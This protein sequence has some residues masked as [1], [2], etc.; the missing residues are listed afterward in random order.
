MRQMDVVVMALLSVAIGC[1][2]DSPEVQVGLVGG[3]ASEPLRVAAGT[4]VELQL[5]ADDSDDDSWQCIYGIEFAIRLESIS[6]RSRPALAAE[7][8]EATG[9]ELFDRVALQGLEPGLADLS[10]QATGERIGAVVRTIPIEV[11]RAEDVLFDYRLRRSVDQGF[12]VHVGS[13]VSAPEP[14]YLDAAGEPLLGRVDVALVSGS[15]G[16]LESAGKYSQINVGPEPGWVELREPLL[17]ELTSFEAVDWSSAERIEVAWPGGSP[18]E[19]ER[20]YLIDE[21]TMLYVVP[22]TADGRSVRHACRRFTSPNAV[23]AG[24]LGAELTVEVDNGEIARPVEAADDEYAWLEAPFF[25]LSKVGDAG[26]TE[27]TVEVAGLVDTFV[28]ES[29][30]P[31]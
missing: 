4:R 14:E 20:V 12:A 28:V 29:V 7:K 2:E 22:Y 21:R 8:I 23:C 13:T 27:V 30:L 18:I 19:D 17:G 15:T 24:E 26:A 9:F 10:I 25:L 11:V 16:E 3:G 5:C 31:Y 6:P 1:G